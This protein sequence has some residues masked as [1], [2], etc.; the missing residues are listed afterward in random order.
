MYEQKGVSYLTQE[1]D[2]IAAYE[3]KGKEKSSEAMNN[4]ADTI[5]GMNRV[6]QVELIQGIEQYFKTYT[7]L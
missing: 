2:T 3:R 4:A 1:S 7:C 6:Q 5:S